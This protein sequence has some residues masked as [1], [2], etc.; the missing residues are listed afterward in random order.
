MHGNS[1]KRAYYSAVYTA[2]E[3]EVRVARIAA[4][5]NRQRAVEMPKGEE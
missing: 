1:E 2:G 4:G 5:E 3:R